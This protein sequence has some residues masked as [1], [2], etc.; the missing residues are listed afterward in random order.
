MIDFLEPSRLAECAVW[1]VVFLFSLTLHEAAHAWLARLGGD[2]TA[3]LG[4]QVSLSPLPHIRR[5]PVGTIIV[6]IASFF[7]MGWM[8][9][10]ASTPFDRDW[11]RRHPRREAA[12]SA[13]GPAANLLIALAA[14]L[15]MRL[16]VQAGQFVPPPDGSPLGFSRLVQPAPNLGGLS[17]LWPA[18][19]ALSIAMTLNV[20]LFLF[21]LLPIPP[22]DGSGVLHGLFPDSIG[23]WLDTL[24]QNPVIG[25]VGVLIAWR[26][27]PYLFQPVFAVLISFVY[28]GF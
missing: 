7:L 22:M 27:I 23:R 13:A 6:P 10:W 16:L 17:L 26:L 4:G 14:M 5:E 9:G 25:L 3:Y 15:C 12:M 28:Q 8:M 20:L 11:A 18:A 24:Q 21:N 19:A 2:D 1:F